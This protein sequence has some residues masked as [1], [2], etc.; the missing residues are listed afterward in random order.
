MDKVEAVKA[1]RKMCSWPIFWICHVLI[2]RMW[3]WQLV[4]NKCIF[5]SIRGTQTFKS[6][7]AACLSPT[8]NASL[9]QQLRCI[10]K[11]G[12]P[13]CI[14]QTMCTHDKS[15]LLSPSRGHCLGPC[16]LRT[17]FFTKLFYSHMLDLF[18]QTM[19]LLCLLFLSVLLFGP[20]DSVYYF[21]VLWVFLF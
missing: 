21:I 15:M 17:I 1:A 2:I 3:K 8:H 16:L 20:K 4:M 19:C 11:T 9:Y 6:T 14:E 10:L 5:M 7:L 12:W 18:Y 13:V